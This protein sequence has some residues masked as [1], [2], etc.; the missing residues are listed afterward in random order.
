MMSI[1]LRR[2]RV[3][4]GW[5]MIAGML[6]LARSLAAQ[7]KCQ[8]FLAGRQVGSLKSSVLN[9]ASGLAASR[10]NPDVLWVHNDAG[11]TARVFAMSTS[12]AEL[13]TYNFGG[14]GARDFEDIA[15]GPGPGDGVDYLYVGDIG[16]NTAG[17][18]DIKVY[19]VVEPAV[20]A[21][22]SPVEKTLSGVETIRLQ[23]PDGPRDAETL[24]VDPV[25]RDIYIV[26]KR[27]MPS[28]VYRAAYPQSTSKTMIMKLVATLPWGGAVGG[29]ISPAGDMVIIRGYFYASIWLRPKGKDLWDSF[30]GSECPVPVV[31]EPQGEAV[32]FAAD[33]AGYYTVSERLYEP[34]YYFAQERRP[35][36]KIAGDLNL[37]GAVNLLDFAM[38]VE[39]WLD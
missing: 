34:I 11:D 38:L 7:D 39:S 27:E 14:V 31:P 10:K 2:A 23:Y 26:S 30:L 22:Q 24:M 37:D 16:D 4:A 20:D 25:N 12:G 3:V 29:D 35:G 8:H 18:S 19:R 15:I 13:G 5:A 36:K 28:K 1:R 33:G 9:E 32:C 6:F 21:N 17:R